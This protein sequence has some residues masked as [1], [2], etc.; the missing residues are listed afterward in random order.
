LYGPSCA[1]QRYLEQCA[2]ANLEPSDRFLLGLRL[3]DL[4]HEATS[5]LASIFPM[6][7]LAK[8]TGHK[9]PRMPLRYYHPKPED[10][11]KKLAQNTP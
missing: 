1:R 9:D 6:Y 3:H 7:E 5:R 8:I 11:A 2:K 4:R 10:T